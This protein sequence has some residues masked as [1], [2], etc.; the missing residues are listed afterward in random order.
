[1]R[2]LLS[3]GRIMRRQS[4]LVIVPIVLILAFVLAS[5]G[6]NTGS[7]SST[8]STG[9]TPTSAPPTVKSTTGCPNNAVVNPAPVNPNVTIRL[10][11]SNGTIVAHNGDLIEVRIIGRGGLLIVNDAAFKQSELDRAGWKS[12]PLGDGT[13]DGFRVIKVD[14]ERL[15]GKAVEGT[16]VSAK[17][18]SRCK[19]FYALGLVFW[20][21]SRDV[22][23]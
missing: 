14:F 22:E 1:M 23:R 8:G 3:N 12:N 7:G 10:T 2:K 11:N 9:S 15:V 4:S 6:T 21:Y 20:I 13:L 17:D 5:C 16:G 18:A 19:N